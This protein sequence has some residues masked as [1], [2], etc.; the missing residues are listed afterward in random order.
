MQQALR[1]RIY[2]PGIYTVQSEILASRK[3]VHRVQNT[4]QMILCL[5]IFWLQP[6]HDGYVCRFSAA[7]SILNR[8]RGVSIALNI[9]LANLITLKEK[10][11]KEN[12]K[13][14]TS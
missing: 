10:R 13:L 3:V 7:E 14:T 4:A 6:R 5:C 9:P 11:K 2:R 12:P 8:T 1:T